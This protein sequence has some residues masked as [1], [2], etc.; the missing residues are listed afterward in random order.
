MRLLIVYAVYERAR[1]QDTVGAE[2]RAGG[3][4][5]GR[6]TFGLVEGE[7]DD[8]PVGVEVGVVEQGEEPVIEPVAHE[9]DRCVVSLYN[10]RSVSRSGTEGRAHTSL[11]RL[12]V[13]KFH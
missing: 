2:G 8:G 5:G 10:S 9:V 13:M 4:K 3:R 6:R 1:Q 7:E 12:G 11:T